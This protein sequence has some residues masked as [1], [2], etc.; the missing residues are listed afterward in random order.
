MPVLKQK[1]TQ[2]EFSNALQDARLNLKTRGILA[3][4][5]TME[6]GAEFTLEGLAECM[7]DSYPIILRCVRDLERCGYVERRGVYE[8]G[9]KTGSE[10][11]LC[12]DNDRA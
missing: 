9:Y 10:Y 6:I 12:N 4:L 5:Q 2:K 11:R 3:T 1:M 7:P 8:G